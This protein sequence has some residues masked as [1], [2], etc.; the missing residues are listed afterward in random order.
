MRDPIRRVQLAAMSGGRPELPIRQPPRTVV[1]DT[2]TRARD[3]LQKRRACQASASA[4]AKGPW[5]AA[6]PHPPPNVQLRLVPLLL[7]SLQTGVS[8]SRE[9]GL[10][11]LDAASGVHILESAGVKRVTR[12]ANVD[13]QFG[14]RAARL[15]CIPAAAGYRRLDIIRVDAFLHC[16]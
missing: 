3:A 12:V 6:S 7:G 11:L 13:F 4:T 8:S 14:P 16:L 9:L 15:E 10:E 1:R 2:S 5:N